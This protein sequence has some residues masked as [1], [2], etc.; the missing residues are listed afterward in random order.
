MLQQ[1]FTDQ[2][3]IYTRLRIIKVA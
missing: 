3:S 1:V 2:N